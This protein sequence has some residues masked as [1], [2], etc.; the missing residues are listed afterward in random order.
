VR[1]R[2]VARHRNLAPQIAALNAM[3]PGFTPG[4]IF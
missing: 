3:A 4:A 2:I 1:E